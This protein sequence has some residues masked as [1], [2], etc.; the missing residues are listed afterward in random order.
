[1]M[2]T[3][4]EPQPSTYYPGTTLATIRR[5]AALIF[6]GFTWL[7]VERKTSRKSL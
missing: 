4:A 6:V 5:N 7:S 2:P 3:N 1:M